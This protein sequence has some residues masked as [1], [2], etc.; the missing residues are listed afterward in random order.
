MIYL[1]NAATSYPKAP[2]VEESVFRFLKEIGANAGRSSYKSARDSARIIYQCRKQMAK[3]LNTVHEERICFCLNTTQ[4]LNIAI[5]GLIKPGF[6]ILTSPLEHNSVMRPLNWLKNRIGIKIE[7]FELPDFQVNWQHLEDQMQKGIDLIVF[8][9]ASNVT[10]CILPYQ[11]IADLARNYRIPVILDAAQAIGSLPIKADNYDV[12]CFPGHKGLLAPMGTGGLYVNPSIE[13][14]SFI[15]GGTGSLSSQEIQPEEL[16]DK[17]ESGTPNLPGL[18]GLNTAL[19]FI[20]KTG[21][22]NIRQRKGKLTSLLISGL[23]EID[24]IKLLSPIDLNLQAGVVSFTSSKYT[25]S[26]LAWHLDKANIASRMGLHCAPSAH[27]YLNTYNTGGTLRFS[28]GYFNT[29]EEI[30]TALDLL[31]GL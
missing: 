11:E 7:Q 19:D 3:V 1:D 21:I 15:Q 5:K 10:G 18:A 29:E 9:A 4:A 16:P 8:T 6:K 30:Y 2:G 12:V 28:P 27:I 25:V 24:H 20:L 13:I 23:K 31:K 17:L 26:E 22:D 14:D